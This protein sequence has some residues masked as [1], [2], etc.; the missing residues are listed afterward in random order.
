MLNFLSHQLKSG[1]QPIFT[2]IERAPRDIRRWWGFQKNTVD[3][4]RPSATPFDSTALSWLVYFRR[5][6]QTLRIKQ[7]S[8]RIVP[9]FEQLC[10]D[11]RVFLYARYFGVP[12]KRNPN[13]DEWKP[14]N[15][16]HKDPFTVLLVIARGIAGDNPRHICCG[17]WLNQ[18]DRSNFAQSLE[19][20]GKEMCMKHDPLWTLLNVR[21]YQNPVVVWAISPGGSSRWRIFAVKSREESAVQ[22]GRWTHQFIFPYETIGRV[23]I[24]SFDIDSDFQM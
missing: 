10:H 16:L 1:L 2:R 17:T 6:R 11:T 23:Y 3:T 24:E 12:S 20:T 9:R 7:I 22:I 14:V 18:R 19:S 4:I 21:W 13:V 5:Y 15:T 8:D